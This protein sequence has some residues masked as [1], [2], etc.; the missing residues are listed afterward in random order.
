MMEE[1]VN[2]LRRSGAYA[3]EDATSGNGNPTGEPQGD[4]EA[5]ARAARNA[6]YEVP[7]VPQGQKAELVLL[8]PEMAEE[9][10]AGDFRNRNVST[11]H[12]GLLVEDMQDERFYATNQAMGLDTSGLLVDGQHRAK[13]IIESDRPQ[14]MWII[15]GV[16]PDA[17]LALDR[18]R[19]RTVGN[20]LQMRGFKNSN[21]L[22]S[23]ARLVAQAETAW[24]KDLKMTTAKSLS[25][26]HSQI[27]EDILI[28]RI[29]ADLAG[30]N[31]KQLS[32]EDLAEVGLDLVEAARKFYE[33]SLG[34]PKLP[35]SVGGTF[36]YLARRY[37]GI[38]ETEAFVDQAGL[39]LGLTSDSPAKALRS[40]IANIQDDDNQRRA[41]SNMEYLAYT[42][43][44]FN[45]F[46]KGESAKR[47]TLP[48]NQ[49]LPK[50]TRRAP[51]ERS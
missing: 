27:V 17:A 29:L 21:E 40:K 6:G 41:I 42:I 8:T 26:T 11:K 37:Y 9:L 34:G 10:L 19:S 12:V 48:T 2:R 46:V 22:G 35:K 43:I 23:T 44:A 4:L 14:W 49:L 50:I 33:V 1:I 38:E 20:D 51:A 36:Y 45:K 18:N 25:F 16:S 31:H 5:Q 39:G 28:A 30:N 15:S 13:G 24:D 47:L 32:D 3:E 7:P